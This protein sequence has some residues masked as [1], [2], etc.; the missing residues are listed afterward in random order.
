[1]ETKQGVDMSCP[2]SLVQS[3]L[4]FPMG[5]DPLKDAWSAPDG[6]M[7][8]VF[9]IPLMEGMLIWIEP[10]IIKLKQWQKA[11]SSVDI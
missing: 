3:S 6:H 9:W 7:N 1:M 2:C 4:S 8:K 5:T 11:V 10:V